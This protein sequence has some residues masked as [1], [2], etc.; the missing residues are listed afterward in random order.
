MSAAAVTLL[1]QSS[2]K[3]H[4]IHLLFYVFNDVSKWTLLKQ[5]IL[6]VLM[7]QNYTI[8]F[9]TFTSALS[10]FTLVIFYKLMSFISNNG[11][12]FCNNT[13][14]T[15]GPDSRH[16]GL[17][18]LLSLSLIFHMLIYPHIHM[19]CMCTCFMLVVTC[20]SKHDK[21]FMP[22]MHIWRRAYFPRCFCCGVWLNKFSTC[23]F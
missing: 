7:I 13:S 5:S 9:Q 11:R 10:C 16:L 23:S 4:C 18:M 14:H 3:I 1:L 2:F 17:W 20:Y 21:K 22:M 19:F 8:C 12:L 15:S 6:K